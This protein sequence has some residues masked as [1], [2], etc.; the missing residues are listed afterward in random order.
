[1][2]NE[3]KMWM[4]FLREEK[5]QTYQKIADEFGVTKQHVWEILKDK[6]EPGPIRYPV[7]ELPETFEGKTDDQV[8]AELGLSKYRVIKAR[9]LFRKGKK[10]RIS[11]AKRREWLCRYL[12]GEYKPGSKFARFI[13]DLTSLLHKKQEAL[14]LE[15][16]VQGTEESLADNI[17]SD[18]DRTYRYTARKELLKKAGLYA[19][20]DLIEKGVICKQ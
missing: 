5:K 16:Y 11:V 1:M 15:F 17:N 10:T 12:F 8:A 9:R 14:I 13:I 4:F 7:L 18:T 3:D 2:N 6:V 20:K 19:I